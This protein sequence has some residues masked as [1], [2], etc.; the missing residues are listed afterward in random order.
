[1]RL[2]YHQLNNC[3]IKRP[4]TQDFSEPG[5][6]LGISDKNMCTN[7]QTAIYRYISVCDAGQVVG[8]NMN[9]VRYKRFLAQHATVKDEHLHL[10]LLS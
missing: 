4:I 3:F 9:K 7:A 10:H 2:I 5:S 8:G 1:M 6:S